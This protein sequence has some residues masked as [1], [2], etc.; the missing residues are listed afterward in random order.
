MTFYKSSPINVSDMKQRKCLQVSQN[1]FFFSDVTRL[2][3]YTNIIFM[4]I[5]SSLNFPFQLGYIHSA[6]W[7]GCARTT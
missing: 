6:Y 2:Y 1:L 7:A 3:R 4:L 5:Y